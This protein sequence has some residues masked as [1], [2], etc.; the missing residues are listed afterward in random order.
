MEPKKI[1]NSILTALSEF[2]KNYVQKDDISLLVIKKQSNFTK[3]PEA[4]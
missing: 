2:T 3:R 4:L 1:K